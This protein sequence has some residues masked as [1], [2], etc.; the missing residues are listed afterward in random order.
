MERGTPAT[1]LVPGSSRYQR[2]VRATGAAWSSADRDNAVGAQGAFFYVLF[3]QN[4]GLAEAELDRDIRGTLRRIPY[5]ISGD[6]PPEDF[7][8]FDPEARCFNDLLREPA[9]L[10][11]W[12]SAEDFDVFVSEFERKGTFPHGLNW[13]RNLDRN[14]ELLA[15][16]ANLKLLQPALFIGAERDAIFGLTREGVAATRERVP[17]LREPVWE[18]DCGHWIQQEEPEVVNAVLLE[19]LAS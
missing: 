7:C 1:R 4:V 16:F 3:F 6:I 19:F 2:A 13:Y 18:P 10:P 11:D 9:A 17:Q 8:F 5:S 12:L 14:W 15:P